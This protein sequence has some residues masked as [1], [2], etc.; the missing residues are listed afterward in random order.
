MRT[1]TCCQCGASGTIRSFYSL[2]GKV[3]CGHCVGKASREATAQGL[4]SEYVS[5]TDNSVCAR[6]GADNGTADFQL[7]GKHAFCPACSTIIQDWQY[8]QWL[9]LGL[10]GLLALLVV[11]LVHGRQYFHAGRSMYI[12]EHLV[13]KRQYAQALPLL[14]ETLRVAPRS[15]KAALLT[16][17]AAL[18][19]GNVE[20]AQKAFEGHNGGRFQDAQDP[21]FVEVDAI[22]KRAIAALEKA[23]QATKLAQQDG[24]GVEAARL[25]HEAEAMYPEAP[26]LATLAEHFDEWAAFDRKDYD[27][28]L[29]ITQ[30]QWK[31]QPSSETAAALSSALACKYAV[32]SDASYRQQSE[33]ML[34]R[35][36]EL[37]QNDDPEQRSFKEYE[38]RIRYRLDSKQIISKQEYDRRFRKDST[39]KN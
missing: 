27:A 24:R 22:W 30:K 1:G 37:A 26:G 23:D 7:V 16:A 13:E 2:S 6:C 20:V 38:G 21:R 3:Y 17:K 25:M 18:L 33:E 10:V 5:L 39:A 36:K 32:T 14:Q 9:K 34:A 11:A 31:E 28:F 4:P 8:P 19:S 35:A 12:G 29:S 15:D